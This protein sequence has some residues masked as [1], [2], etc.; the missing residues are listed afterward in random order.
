MMI[1]HMTMS[2]FFIIECINR[3][4]FVKT[5]IEVKIIYH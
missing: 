3:R 2:Y 5:I 4:W 1:K